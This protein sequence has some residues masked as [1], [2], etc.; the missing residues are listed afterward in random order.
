MEKLIKELSGHSGSKITLVKNDD[1]LFVRKEK[2]VERNFERLTALYELGFSVPKIYKK[3]DDVL[4]MEY[5]PGLDMQTYLQHNNEKMLTKYIL[6]LFNSFSLNAVDKD[7]TEVYNYKLKWMDA[8]VR[9]PFT[10]QELIDTLPKVLP[11]SYYHGDLTLENIIYSFG[12]FYMIDPVTIEYDS[13]VFDIAK[14]RQ[15]LH[16]KWFLRNSDVR[17]DTKLRNI[18]DRLLNKY[19]EA[20]NNQLLI[21]MLLRVYLHTEKNDE[22]YTFIMREI[23]K[24]WK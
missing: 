2:N 4:E 16:C 5:I 10:R 23:E 24:L 9:L 11:K 6:D 21:L 22:N 3:Y 17:L 13:Y 1:F 7:Y 18:E 15:D 14:M 20:N 8:D 12:T 19:P